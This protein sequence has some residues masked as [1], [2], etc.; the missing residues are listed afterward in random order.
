MWLAESVYEVYKEILRETPGLEVGVFISI[1]DLHRRLAITTKEV[2]SMIKDIR[3]SLKYNVR[4]AKAPGTFKG[5]RYSIDGELWAFIAMY[6]YTNRS[7]A[8]ERIRNIAKGE[9]QQ[10]LGIHSQKNV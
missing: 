10:Q 8:E 7:M 2:Q 9:V 5:K 3:G 4:L 1:E 6:P